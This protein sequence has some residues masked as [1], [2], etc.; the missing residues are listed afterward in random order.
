MGGNKMKSA[1][2]K[3]NTQGKDRVRS[4]PSPFL[5]SRAIDDI[6]EQEDEES[7]QDEMAHE[8]GD[9][10][11]EEGATD[12]AAVVGGTPPMKSSPSNAGRMS[13]KTQTFTVGARKRDRGS[14]HKPSRLSPRKAGNMALES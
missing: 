12:R 9:A 5:K 1:K 14:S 8:D 10:G 3:L 13:S 11:T 2:A 7:K 4:G 6:K